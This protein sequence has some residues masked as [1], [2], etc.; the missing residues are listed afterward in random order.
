M[1]DDLNVV[2]K[3]K[4]GCVS[5]FVGAIA[6][7]CAV[8]VIESIWPTLAVVIGLIGL[9]ALVAGGIVIYRKVRTRW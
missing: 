2:E 8:G 5:I 3:F 7:Y 9:V 4:R 1:S 6:M